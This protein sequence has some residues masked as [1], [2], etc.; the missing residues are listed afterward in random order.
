MMHPQNVDCLFLMQAKR[1]VC[2]LTSSMIS[3]IRC[4]SIH[5]VPILSILIYETTSLASRIS[6]FHHLFIHGVLIFPLL[7]Y[8]ITSSS[9]RI[10]NLHCLSIRGV[11]IFSINIGN[12]EAGDVVS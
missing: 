2:G 3:F 4:I 1:F 11:L 10:S 9:S 7:I 8:E 6:S 12:M 5:G